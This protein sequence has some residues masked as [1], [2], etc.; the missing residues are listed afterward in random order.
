MSTL[1]AERILIGARE[2]IENEPETTTPSGHRIIRVSNAP[3]DPTTEQMMRAVELSGALD[4]WDDEGEDIY[5]LEDGE[6]V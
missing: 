3:E 2:I 4:F 1:G 6:P 5:T